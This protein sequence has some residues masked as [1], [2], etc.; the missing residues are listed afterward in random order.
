MTTDDPTEWTWPSQVLSPKMYKVLRTTLGEPTNGVPFTR[1]SELRKKLDELNLRRFTNKNKW[2]VI[3]WRDVKEI[4]EYVLKE[5]NVEV[6]GH[7]K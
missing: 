3:L 6:K 7:G 1:H 2:D 4:F 5:E